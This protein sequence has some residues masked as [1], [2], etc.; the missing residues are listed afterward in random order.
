MDYYTDIVFEVYDA[1]PANVRSMFGGGR[2]DGL[3]GL[4]GVEPVPTAGFGMGDVTLQN[5]L[6]AHRLLPE[7]KTETDAIV[8][9]IGDVYDASQKVLKKLRA[10]GLN[11]A[12]DSSGRKLDTQ[13]RH[14]AKSGARYAVF[15]GDKE[16]SAGQAKL[17]DL[18]NGKEKTLTIDKLPGA[19]AD[20]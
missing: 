7:Q 4:F 1:D 16:L 19:L 13:I 8:I 3:V 5:F 11:L 17:R 2:Y 18:D 10:S 14:A 6:Q 15:I 9:L 12:V 20:R